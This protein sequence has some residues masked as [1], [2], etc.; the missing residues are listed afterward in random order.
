LDIISLS[1]HFIAFIHIII[2]HLNNNNRHTWPFTRIHTLLIPRESHSCLYVKKVIYL[3]GRRD[4]RTHLIKLITSQFMPI[5]IWSQSSIEINW[6][7]PKFLNNRYIISLSLSLF[8]KFIYIA[9]FLE[10]GTYEKD[11]LVLNI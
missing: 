7:I 6:K 11:C 9:S 1:C 2:S 10:D 3:T 8:T 4:F 5:W